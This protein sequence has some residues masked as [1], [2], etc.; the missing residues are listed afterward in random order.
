MLHVRN[1]VP[2]TCA[3][4]CKRLMDERRLCGHTYLA[5]AC[6]YL[7]NL[8]TTLLGTQEQEKKGLARAYYCIGHSNASG[9]QSCRVLHACVRV[10]GTR[11]CRA[12]NV[13]T[14]E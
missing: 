8:C 6:V 11:L 2:S 10:N 5:H 1:R 3:A 12:C 7:R 13:H 9:A 4:Q 14:S